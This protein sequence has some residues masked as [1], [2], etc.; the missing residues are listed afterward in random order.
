MMLLFLGVY[1]REKICG[2]I[3]ITANKGAATTI[4]MT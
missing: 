3:E 4:T 1:I 2:A